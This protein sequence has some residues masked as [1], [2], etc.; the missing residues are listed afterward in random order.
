MAPFSFSIIPSINPRLCFL[1]ASGLF[2]IFSKLMDFIVTISILVITILMAPVILETG[3]GPDTDDDPAS[4]GTIIGIHENPGVNGVPR[5]S[6]TAP[7]AKG[8][9]WEVVDFASVDCAIYWH[10]LET[11]IKCTDQ[12]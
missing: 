7:I 6:F 10:S 4:G 2:P 9:Y 3:T 8:E 5:A 12:D 1:T 11:L